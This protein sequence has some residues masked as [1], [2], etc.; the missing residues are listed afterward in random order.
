MARRAIPA[1]RLD[2]DIAQL[3][4]VLADRSRVAMLDALLDG[5][6]HTIGALARHAGVTAATASGHL[7]RLI[8]ERLVIV[9]PR[10]RERRVR[11]AGPGVAQLLES[12]AAL[13]HRAAWVAPLTASASLRAKELRFARTCYD[14]LA[15]VVG[16]R[17]TGA[18]LDRSWLRE[19]DDSFSAQPALLAWLAEQGRPLA[20]EPHSR[21]PLARACLDWSERTPHLAGRIGAA[22]ADLALANQWVVR[23]RSSRALRL[24]T[25]GKAALAS[26]LAVTFP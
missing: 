3:A 21:R 22:I 15:G 18:L 5:G 1:P 13:A 4:G 12:L 23:V 8:D 26:E 11:L 6:S 9:D 10:G 16:V 2:P 14:H 7:R 20:D 25:R 19:Q 17:V 24:T